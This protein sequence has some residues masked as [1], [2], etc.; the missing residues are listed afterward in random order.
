[1]KK[2]NK[3]I[4]DLK[5]EVKTIKK[6]RM[7]A[8]LEMESLGKRLGITDA[9]ITNRIQEIEENLR[10]RRYHGRDWHNCQRKFKTW[11]TTHPKGP[12]N[13]RHNEKTKPKNIQNRE[14]RFPAQRTWKYLQQNQTIKHLQPK[15]RDGHNGTRSL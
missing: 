3:A 4:Q 11:K 15:E 8:S 5:L 13:S 2:L 10:C 6:T 7:E 9:S 12:G 1:M 14:Q